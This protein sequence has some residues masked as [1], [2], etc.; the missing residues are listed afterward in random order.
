MLSEEEENKHV[1]VRDIKEGT[2]VYA[3]LQN[4]R[5]ECVKC[6]L[7]GTRKGTGRHLFELVLAAR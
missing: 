5:T 1:V 4:M 7:P 3:I 2:F 6:L